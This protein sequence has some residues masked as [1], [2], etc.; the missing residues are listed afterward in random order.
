MEY[1]ENGTF[2]H[3]ICDCGN[4]VRVAQ[5]SLK[6][7]V[8]KSC[9]CYKREHAGEQ[10][11]TDLTGMHIGYLTGIERIPVPGGHTRYRC[12]C[13][14][15]NET[16]VDGPN[17][18]NG[19]IRSCGCK[20]FKSVG[21]ETIETFLNESNIVYLPQHRFDGCKYKRELPFDFFLP[22]YNVCI[23][24]QGIQH[25]EPV[26]WFYD[27]ENTFEERQKR[28]QI[29]REYCKDNGILLIEI[30]YFYNNEKIKNTIINTL[31]P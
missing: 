10:S 8:T 3:C 11:R 15:G 25:Y 27:T 13:D 9:G 12:I 1:T 31:N 22:D 18:L 26:E 17:W 23:E 7:D 28:D 19:S 24:Y 4:E 20:R 21:E 29:K 14:C 5:T 16:V 6:H 2:C 30:P